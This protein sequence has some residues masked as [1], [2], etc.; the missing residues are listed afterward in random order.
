[1]STTLGKYPLL[2]VLQHAVYS[3][4]MTDPKN[5]TPDDNAIC[6]ACEEIKSLI[7][8]AKHVDFINPEDDPQYITPF[9]RSI[10]EVLA[11]LNVLNNQIPFSPSDDNPCSCKPAIMGTIQVCM[12]ALYLQIESDND[13]DT[14]Q[15]EG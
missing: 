12:L 5:G 2:R 9:S 15:M 3:C 11:W 8:L 13:F 6:Q 4:C 10:A 14:A 1:M 7:P